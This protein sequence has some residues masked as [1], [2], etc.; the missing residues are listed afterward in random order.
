MTRNADFYLAAAHDAYDA[1]FASKTA[2]KRAIADLTRAYSF[3]EEAIRTDLLNDREIADWDA[4]YW[5]IPDFHNWKPRHSAMF[6]RWDD[7]VAKIEAMVDF[8]A[9]I[10]AADI[11]PPPA[12]KDDR[13]AQISRSIVEIMEARGKQYDRALK[14]ADLF[15]GL[16]VHANVH[17]VRGHK[18]AVFLRAFYYL[19]GEFTPLQVIIAAADELARREKAA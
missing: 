11:A 3:H 14:L 6:A 18:G 1:G 5:G 12:R 2:Q 15:G 7:L 16:P 17:L 9:A 4:L 19:A 13:P 10:K 8:R